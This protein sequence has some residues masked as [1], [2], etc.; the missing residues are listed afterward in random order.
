M[1]NKKRLFVSLGAGIL[2][3]VIASFIILLTWKVLNSPQGMTVLAWRVAWPV[4]L[5]TRVVRIPSLGQG[6]I[7]FS[8]LVS[9]TIDNVIVSGLVYAALSIVNKKGTADISSTA[10]ECL[11]VRAAARSTAGL[12]SQFVTYSLLA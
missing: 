7:V 12:L 2:I 5:S 6:A 4:L 10:S 1:L 11:S 8:F 9:I 3:F